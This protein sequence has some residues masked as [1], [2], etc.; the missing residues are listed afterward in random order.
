MIKRI[1]L[2]SGV[3]G[4]V[5]SLTCSSATTPHPIPRLTNQT[6]MELGQ[7]SPSPRQYAGDAL[8]GFPPPPDLTPGE[9]CT[10]DDKDFDGYR[11]PSQIAHC[12]RNVSR[13]EKIA[14]GASYGVSIDEL[15]LYEIDHYIPLSIGGDNSPRNLWPLVKKVARAK[16]VVEALVYQAVAKGELN[17]DEAIE[18]IKAWR[19]YSNSFRID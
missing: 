15:H 13:R 18:V 1:A 14:V 9:L 11:Y 4:L 10:P 8:Q 19:P 6:S 12:R 7:T 16:S 2:T 5:F 17:Q 3:F